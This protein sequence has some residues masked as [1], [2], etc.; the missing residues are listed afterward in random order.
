[1]RVHMA[2]D[3]VRCARPRAVA[4][5]PFTQGAAQAFIISQPQIVVAAKGQQLA[6]RF[7]RHMCTVTLDN[8]A[9][10]AVQLP[11]LQGL[12]ALFDVLGIHLGFNL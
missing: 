8:G 1:V 10:K 12:Q 9:A 2:A 3:E 11:G 4:L 7:Q 5:R 6:P